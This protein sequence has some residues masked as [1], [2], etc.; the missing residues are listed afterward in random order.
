MARVKLL[1]LQ[2]LDFCEDHFWVK[3]R[4]EP[5]L[6]GEAIKKRLEQIMLQR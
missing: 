2:A 6:G 1:L 5:A 4:I 3:F